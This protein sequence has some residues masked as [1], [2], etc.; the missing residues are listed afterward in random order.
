MGML[1]Y[2]LMKCIFWGLKK[3]DEKVQ[4]KLQNWGEKSIFRFWLSLLQNKIL[5]KNNHTMLLTT[6]FADH[7]IG[8]IKDQS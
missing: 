7:N 1:V 2:P 6:I 5:M 3:C 4:L 8:T